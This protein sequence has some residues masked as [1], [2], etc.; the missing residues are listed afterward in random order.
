M[1]DL[2]NKMNPFLAGLTGLGEG[3]FQGFLTRKK[4]DDEQNQFNQKMA[5]EERQNSLLWEFRRA[6]DLRQQQI[7]DAQIN[8]INID[9]Q[10]ADEALKADKNKGYINSYEGGFTEIDTTTSKPKFTPFQNT[11]KTGKTIKALIPGTNN[12]GEY[13]PTTKDFVRDANNKPLIVDINKP[14]KPTKDS[15]DFGTSIEEINKLIQEEEDKGGNFWVVVYC[16][17]PI[18]ALTLGII[19]GYLR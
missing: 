3:L 13:D 8:N 7:A 18:V 11:P 14:E 4:M 19:H 6:D 1:A 12:Y 10:R 9:N 15:G 17:I 5:M 2:G 16:L